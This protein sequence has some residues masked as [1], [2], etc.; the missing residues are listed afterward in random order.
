MQSLWCIKTLGSNP[1]SQRTALI[2]TGSLG[3]EEGGGGAWGGGGAEQEHT[4]SR[5][6]WDASEA[7]SAAPPIMLDFFFC[8]RSASLCAS[9]DSFPAEHQALHGNE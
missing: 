1:T 6:S 2:Q 9:L 3:R 4:L 7:L 8:T 5:R